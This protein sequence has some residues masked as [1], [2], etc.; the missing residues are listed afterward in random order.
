MPSNAPTDATTAITLDSANQRLG[1]VFAPW[2]QTL[3]LQIDA[4]DRD[5]LIMRLP[6]SDELC[7]SGNIICGQALMAL[8]DTCMVFVCYSGLGR[9]SNVATVGQ[10]TSFL[11]PARNSDV[12]AQGKVIKA[13]RSL[14]FGE[15]TLITES[16]GK[17]VCTGTSTYAVIPD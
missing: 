1:E 10:N 17:T 5:G 3:N 8:I 11:R 16:D 4:L 9:Y 13:G 15:V 12:L 6:Y 7:R 14:V 2:I